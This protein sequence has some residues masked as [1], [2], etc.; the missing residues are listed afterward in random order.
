M[1]HRRLPMIYGQPSARRGLL[2]SP[3]RFAALLF[4][5]ALAMATIT[6]FGTDGVVHLDRLRRDRRR[7]EERAFA[8]LQRNADLSTQIT[9][10]AKDDRHLESV[11]R[12]Q[13]GLARADEIVYRFE[14]PR[15]HAPSARRPAVGTAD[16][17]NERD[18]Q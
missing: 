8:L 13:L 9:R 2:A 12:K 18:R 4:T 1:P 7:L 3:K 11:A 6:V 5:L 17:R 16:E 10:L 15:E 14:G